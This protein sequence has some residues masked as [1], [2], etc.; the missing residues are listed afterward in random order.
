LDDSAYTG[1]EAEFGILDSSAHY[2]PAATTIANII[3]ILKDPG[4]AFTPGSLA[5]TLSGT[6]VAAKAERHVLSDH[7]DGSKLL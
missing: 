5:Y 7:L 1:S 6:Y 3:S 4:A 2:K